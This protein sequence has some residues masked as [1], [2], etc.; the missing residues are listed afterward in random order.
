MILGKHYKIT[1]YDAFNPGMVACPG[2]G[3][4]LAHSTVFY[5]EAVDV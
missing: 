1:Y 3:V 5:D 4:K 2:P